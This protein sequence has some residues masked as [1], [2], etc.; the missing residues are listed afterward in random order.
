MQNVEDIYSLAPMQQ[1]MLFHSL[2]ETESGQYMVP[3]SSRLLFWL[4]QIQEQQ[5]ILRQ[6]VHS[7]L[8]DIHTWCSWTPG[9]PLFQCFLRFQNY[10][11]DLTLEQQPGDLAYPAE[12]SF[13]DNRA[14]RKGNG[15]TRQ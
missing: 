8:T 1:G 10:P 13:I 5:A 4:Q 7:S 11:K 2:Y 9:Q 3:S 14:R 15:K 12:E 6:Y